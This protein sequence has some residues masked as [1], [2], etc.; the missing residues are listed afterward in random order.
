MRTLTVKK[1]SGGQ[2][3]PGWHEIVVSKANYGDFQGNKYI[4]IL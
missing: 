1:S 2:Y 3:K 4:D